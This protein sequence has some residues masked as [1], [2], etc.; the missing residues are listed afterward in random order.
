[1]KLNELSIGDLR[2]RMTAGEVDPVQA[3]EAALVA[4]GARE[5]EVVAFLDVHREAALARARAL[6]ESGDYRSL[7]LGGVP[8]AIKDNI[9]IR[10]SSTTCGSR[11]LGAYR[12][13]YT[14]T[15]VEKLHAAG[16]VVIGKTNLDEFAMGSSTE[17]SGFGPTHNPW[18][19]TRAPGG[20]SGGSAAA[21]AAGMAA[22]SLGSDTGGSIRQPASFCGVV[23]MKPTYGRVSRYGLVAFASSLD[24][25]GPFTR[26]VGDCATMLNVM[27]G[28]DPRDATSASAP[29]PDFSSDL[30][31]GLKGVKIGVPWSFL[32]ESLDP[33]V[34][35]SFKAAVEGARREG[36]VIEDVELPHADHG[37]AAYYIIANAEAS[38]N[39]ARFDGVRY[40]HRSP[41]A[42]TLVEMYTRT[43]EEGFGA[44]VKRRV[45][46][47]TYV[48]SAGY[49]DAYY[50]R[51]Q[52]V[53][54]LIIADFV[55][56]FS[57][58]DTV[59]LPTA[60]TTAFKLGEKTDDPI[61]MYMNDVF[62]IPVNLAG[63]P[64]ISIPCGLSD[65]RLP[66]GVQ[67]VG[68][69][70]QEAPLLR[71]AAGLER[72]VDFPA[73]AVAPALRG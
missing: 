4:I 32:G 2:K 53:R 6:S 31:R 58:C 50:K 20:S 15:V 48:L 60:P 64:G 34:L 12:P 40:G 16:A 29:V 47:G 25:I 10:G 43:R 67:L 59:M 68:R 42:E 23:G 57:R 17:N 54:S 33:G 46:L 62:T 13:P 3:C 7:P 72:L 41:H 30:D 52:Q 35:A 18:D 70:F 38:A 49:Y 19:T 69:A 9:C 65:E 21:V 39:L 73:G 51:A 45:L 14:A 26:T 5:G 28:R 44:E 24:Q 1:M 36:A 66:I 8:V 71:V 22:A 55:R 11:I 56:A 37:L 27:C 61:L 63:L